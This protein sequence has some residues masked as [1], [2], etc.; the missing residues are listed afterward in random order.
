MKRQS[1][2]MRACGLK[3]VVEIYNESETKSTKIPC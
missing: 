2:K 1:Q 3:N